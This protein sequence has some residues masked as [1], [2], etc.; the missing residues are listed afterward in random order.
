MEIILIQFS[1]EIFNYFYN[2]FLKNLN[3]SPK[4]ITGHVKLFQEHAED[5][6]F[7]LCEHSRVG[8]HDRT[9]LIKRPAYTCIPLN[10]YLYKC[11]LICGIWLE[12]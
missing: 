12:F 9:P 6:K 7:I 8:A 2:S 5:E 4:F 10:T 1:E 3:I 11:C